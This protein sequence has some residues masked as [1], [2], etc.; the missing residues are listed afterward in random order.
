MPGRAPSNTPKKIS[1]LLNIIAA[2]TAIALE[3]ARLFKEKIDAERLAI[4]GVAVAGISHY[5]K[6][7]LMGNRRL[8][9]ASSRQA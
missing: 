3:N 6:N 8:I 4:M 2:H 1:L 9:A 5:I 7:V